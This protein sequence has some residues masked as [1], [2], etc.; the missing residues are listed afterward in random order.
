MTTIPPDWQDPDRTP[1]DF[2]VVGAGA[3]GAPLAARLVERGY[4]VLVVEMGP[5][6]PPRPTGAVVE[7]TEVPLLHTETTEDPRHSLRFFVKHFDND[8]AGSLDPKIHRPAPG[9]RRDEEGIFYPRA[10]GVGGCTVHNAMITV[11]GLSEDWDEIAQATSD[12]SWRGE[13]MRPYFQ[14]VEHCHY[15]RP[16]LWGRL[17]ALLG[18]GTGWEDA[19]HGYRGWLDT[20]LADLGLVKR[21]RQML[22]VV[23]DGVVTSLRAGVDQLGDLLRA[24]LWGRTLPRLDPNNWQTMRQKPVGFCRVPCAVTP[25]GERSSARTRLLNV[26]S[27]HPDRLRLLTGAFVTEILLEEDSGGQVGGRQVCHRARGVC[28][29]IGEH[30]YEAD[31]NSQ[32]RADESWRDRQLAL[33]CRKEVILCGGAFNTPQLL[34]LSGI[35]PA[36]HLRQFEI[37]VRVDLPGVGG[38]LQDRYEI[39]VVATVT[40]RFRSLDGLTMSSTDPDPQLKQWVATAGRAASRRGPYAT[41]G[42]LLGIFMRSSQE[43]AAPDLFIVALPARFIGYSVGYSATSAIAPSLPG[44]PPEFR[45]SLSWLVLKARTRQHAGTVRLQSRSPFRRPEIQFCSFPLASDESLKPAEVA[46]A[47]S[48]AASGPIPCNDAR[49]P[50]SNDQDLEALYEGVCFINEILA[51]GVRAGTIKEYGLPGFERFNN[52][53]RKWIKHVAWGHHACGTCRI[54]A[55]D[56]DRLAV[57]DSRFRVRGVRGLRVVDASVFPQIPGFFIVA[58]IYMIAE[59]A[60]DVIT[61]DHPV[62]EQD[63]KPEERKAVR[64]AL[65][66]DPVFPSS[67]VFEARRLYPAPMEEK[68]AELVA[69][70]RRAAGL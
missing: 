46:D 4:T 47:E 55:D 20:T 44:D 29:L 12:E 25:K 52:N 45:R 59:K 54:G 3:G 36:D 30:L 61:E 14:R 48:A 15:A 57:L 2:I 21:D 35:G 31:P 39:P 63:L 65:R 60:A 34:L 50:R 5:E 42:G 68:E 64:E 70:R 33:H 37:P 10:Q 27:R 51:G 6:K 18:F 17:K 24:A 53:V 32:V 41:N 62:R 8:P 13:R 69:H 26:K 40:D 7:S 19:R 67:P 66:H 16:S 43:D 28:C 22:R 1:L 9:A 56:N 38:N 49:F 58:N 11:C 23:L